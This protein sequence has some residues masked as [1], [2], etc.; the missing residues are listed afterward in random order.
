MKKLLLS[1]MAIAGF[2]SAHAQLSD[3]CKANDFTFTALN[4]GQTINLY[5]M[6]DSGKYVFLDVSATWCGPCW[7]YHNSNALDD[8]FTQHG[9][10]TTSN[11]VRVIW[12]DGDAAT[13]DADMNG[14]GTNT[15]GNWISGTPFPMCNPAAALVNPFNNDYEIG[16]FPTIYMICPDRTIK[17]VGQLT[18]AQL[19]AQVSPTASCPPK[20]NV[21]VTPTDISGKLFSCTGAFTLNLTIKN[22]GFNTL[23]SATI[24]AKNGA[25]VVGSQAWSGSLATYQT[26]NATLNL[27][28]VTNYDSLVIE[29]VATGDQITTNNSFTVYIDNYTNA[30]ALT[31]PN[32][33][34][35]D[36]GNMMP[37]KLGFENIDAMNMFGFY[38]GINGTTK[39]K[40]AAGADTKGV[41][42][43]FYNAPAGTVGTL[44]FGNYNTTTT[45][46][47]LYLD[48][49]VAYA[50]YT[51]SSPEDDKLEIMVSTDCGTSWTQK[52]MKSGN[53]LKTTA[54][55]TSGFIPSSASQWMHHNI[56]ISS[57]KNNPSALIAVKATSDYG[58]YAWLD[59]IKVSASAIPSSINEVFGSAF[60]VYPNPASTILNV[61]GI[62]NKATLNLVDVMGRTIRTATVTSVNNEAQINVAGLDK[63]TYF[64]KITV[65]GQTATKSVV[66]TD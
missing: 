46:P 25:T 65:D 33:E 7:N 27:T 22:R 43:N 29:V 52:W 45:S 3:G 53:N 32:N 40:G 62:E 12:V 30:N 44:I 42:V 4:G 58:N 36:S 24:N 15:Q 61:R 2:A 60:D 20:I 19:Y 31:L 16:Y 8:L 34:N 5:S 1:I 56:D 26:A 51:A 50:Q 14:T 41:F 6:L 18:A 21:D 47:Y 13:T 37:S 38:D 64:L 57:I 10:G 11:D 17:E 66:I 49:D 28:G 9:P 55:T 59:N 63:G 48:M 54:P 35:M 39:M 23:T